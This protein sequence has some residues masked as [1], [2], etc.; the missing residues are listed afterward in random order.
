MLAVKPHSQKF[1]SQFQS[2][3]I[4]VCNPHRYDAEVKEDE[5]EEE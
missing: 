2:L 1:L 4:V 3:S 5:E